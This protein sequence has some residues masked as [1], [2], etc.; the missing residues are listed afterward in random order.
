MNIVISG[1]TGFIGRELC[2]YLEGQGHEVIHLRRKDF[3]WPIHEFKEKLRET[4][5]LIN[6][7]GSP[8]SRRWTFFNRRDIMESRIETTKKILT[9]FKLLKDRPRLFIATSAIG[10]YDNTGTH[11]EES[12]QFGNGFLFQVASAWEAESSKARDLA[13]LRLVVFRLGVVLG[14]QGGAFP[15]LLRI[16]RLGLG[17]RLGKGLQTMSFIH[18]H[19]LIRAY[20]FAM[21]N[22]SVNGVYNLTAPHPTTNRHFTRVLGK[23]L[24]RP[25]FWVVPGFLLKLFF[26]KASTILLD[27]QNA[28]PG[29]LLKEGFEFRYATIEDTIYSLVNE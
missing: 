14:S 15:R 5:V 21:D 17:G 18:I 22:P 8:I 29:R 27:G 28:L 10:I 13:N 7:S 23:A 11:T 2:N 6:L 1:S 25:S 20:R 26:G 4:D 9:A 12:H 24:K 16:F 19:D 3:R